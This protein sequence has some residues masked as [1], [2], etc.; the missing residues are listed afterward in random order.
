MATRALKD[1]TA[2]VWD[3]C[4]GRNDY[5]APA[6]LPEGMACEMLNVVPV[7]GT[8]AQKRRGSAGQTISGTLS[9]Y[10]AMARFVPGQDD[11]A[12]EFHFVTRDATPKIMRV[13][14]GTTATALTLKD[15]I[16]SLPQ[17]ATWAV[18]NGK[19]YWAYD[20]P[21][22]RLHC[23]DP[24]DGTVRRVG[25]GTSGAATVADHGSGSYAATARFYRI[26]MMVVRSG[27][28]Q[29]Q[30]NAGASVTFTPSGSGASARVT[31]PASL[32]GEGETHWQVEGSIDDTVYYI[33][34]GPIVVGTTTYDDTTAPSAYADNTAAPA[35][36]AFTPWPSVKYLVST[37]DR[38]IG[39]GVYESTAGE[40]FPPKDGQVYYSPV[41]DTTDTD[42]DE[43][44]SNSITFKGR[45]GIARNAGSE[46]RAIAG[47]MD[48]Q[49]FVFQSRGTYMLVPT[50]N[51]EQPYD[52]ITLQESIGAVSH[53]STFV[54]EDEA[55]RATVNWLDPEKGPYRYG[56]GGLQW[57]GYDNQTLWS[58]V[59]L[60]ATNKVAHGQWDLNN[61]RALFWIATGA[62]NDPDTV[63]AFQVREGTPTQAE[64]VRYGWA[65]WTGALCAARCSVMFAES[66]GSTMSRR[67]KPYA[68]LSA[69]LLRAEDSAATDDNGTAFQA[70]ALS[71]AWKLDPIHVNKRLGKA[72]VQVKTQAGV[73]IYETL[74]RNYGV[75]SLQTQTLITAVGSETRALRRFDV[76]ELADAFTFQTQ[77]GDV[78][79]VANT[80]TLDHW[81][82]TLEITS[83]ERG[84]EVD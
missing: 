10:N 13:A 63:L 69:S 73:T 5:D 78:A 77:L 15:A 32:P 83:E 82:A 3:A 39:F 11:S 31:I 26:R 41:L 38:L 65:K 8:V 45:I 57:C 49:I 58:T 48:G 42:D 53:H 76:A 60:S 84:N 19:L 79:A 21:V 62:A 33:L 27:R 52:R 29:R 17:N 64:G 40:G 14:A 66:F 50:R 25:M 34:S 56:S 16:S 23:Y 44:V 81:S 68:G 55:G 75:Q 80:W 67:L 37:G 6:E 24:I 43:R 46:D 7:R 28:I 51:A 72:Y 47:P 1:G 36:G 4:R 71:R 61:R 2:I 30:S 35:P 54:A 59:N 20:S 18:L 74:I 70:Y 9:G 22:N 12:A